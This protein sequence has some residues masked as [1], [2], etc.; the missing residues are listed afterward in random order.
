MSWLLWREYRL[1]R[2]TLA[3]GTMGLL[4]PCV[5]V[6]LS[7]L[8]AFDDSDRTDVYAQAWLLTGLCSELTIALL[9]GNA[10]AGERA[11]RSAE[12]I[13]Y[14]PLQRWR[15]MASKLLLLSLAIAVLWGVSRLVLTVYPSGQPLFD[16]PRFPSRL[17]V[18]LAAGWFWSSLQPSS[19]LA[20]AAAYVTHIVIGV[21]AARIVYMRM[22]EPVGVIPNVMK[23]FLEQFFEPMFELYDTIG[24][25]VA[26]VCL[27][28][29]SWN[30]LRRREP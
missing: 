18:I 9:A 17:L 7:L 15:T 21:V 22:E 27:S 8:G 19:V 16:A 20:S 10:I 11:D 24:L 29:G 23:H 4:L 28:I 26:I 5:I 6:F 30:Y 12:F 3:L 2:L 13:A 1:N 25:P 14:L